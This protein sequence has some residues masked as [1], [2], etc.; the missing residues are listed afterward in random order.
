MF[1]YAVPIDHE[2]ACLDMIAYTWSARCVSVVWKGYFMQDLERRYQAFRQFVQTAHDRGDRASLKRFA[3]RFSME[4]QKRAEA[5]SSAPTHVPGADADFETLI[6]VTKAYAYPC[7]WC[8]SSVLCHTC[9]AAPRSRALHT[10]ESY[11]V[12]FTHGVPEIIM[13]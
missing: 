10:L 2:I 11:P 7:S 5:I 13:L 4:E 9:I 6:A 12:S 1:C 8:L 3:R